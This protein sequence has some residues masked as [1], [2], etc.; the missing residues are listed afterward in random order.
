MAP[1]ESLEAAGSSLVL[2]HKEGDIVKDLS[3]STV[4]QVTAVDEES[5]LLTLT[6]PSGY[7]WTAEDHHCRPASERDLKEWEVVRRMIAATL[8]PGET[9]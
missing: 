6:R 9:T 8:D 1:T 3:R 2:L 5:K 4:A 7:S